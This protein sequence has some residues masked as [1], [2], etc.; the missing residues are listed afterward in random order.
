MKRSFIFT[1]VV[2][3]LIA[4]DGNPV[5]EKIIETHP[6][7]QPKVVHLVQM[8]NDK[9]EVVEQKIFFDNGQL[10]IGGK[11]SNG[12]RNGKWVAYF[13]DGTLQSEGEF[14]NG[15]RT[16][17]AKVYFPKGNLRYEGQYKDDKEIGHWKFYN[18]KGKLVK[19][20]DY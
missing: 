13:E 12:K 16:G 19:E 11:L 5:V 20:K 10:K 6:N 8:V 9:E 1:I 3:F 4:C 2:F 14:V 7:N 17:I 18:E 15:V